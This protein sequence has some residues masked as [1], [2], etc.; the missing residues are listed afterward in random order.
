MS[1]TKRSKAAQRL[2]DFLY[3]PTHGWVV[4]VGLVASLTLTI[5][6]GLSLAESHYIQ[7][8]I[9]FVIGVIVMKPSLMYLGEWVDERH[10]RRARRSRVLSKRNSDG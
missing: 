10:R 3:H 9:L 8:L 2:N 5:G 7:G 1:R 4:V 6:A